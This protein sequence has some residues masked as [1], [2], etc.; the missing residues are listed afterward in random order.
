MEHSEIAGTNFSD[1]SI[2]GGSI[3]GLLAA[4]EAAGSGLRVSIFEEHKEIG[5]PEKCDGLVGAAG[6]ARLGIVPPSD[7]IQN[8]ILRA[9]FYSP[10]M[11][12]ITVAAAR[13]NVIVLDRSRFD[14][15]L[16]EQAVKAGASIRVGAR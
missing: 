11:K 6:I 14:K 13:Q 1:V 10:S 7:V 4:R 3:A 15:Y 8:R 12:E 5:I 2:V 9:T 16:A